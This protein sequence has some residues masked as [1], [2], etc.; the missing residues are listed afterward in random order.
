MTLLEAT[1]DTIG[2]SHI[3]VL[4]TARLVLRPATLADAKPI[5]RLIDDRRIAEMLTRVPHPYTLADAEDFLATVNRAG[6]ETVF[7]VTRDSTVLGVCGI[8]QRAGQPPEIGYWLGLP[9]WGNGYA[10]EAT[11]AVIDHAFGDL[12]YEALVSG[13][14]V[15]NP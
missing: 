9:F 12:G 11:R 14:R 3:P 15:S 6:G 13:A 8:A 7:A 1:P 5:A 4:E 2:E 10:T